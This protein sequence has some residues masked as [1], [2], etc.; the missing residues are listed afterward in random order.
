MPGR[1]RTTKTLAQRINLNYFKNLAPIPRWRR[2]LSVVLTA[3]G[4]LWL[5]WEALAGKQQPYNAGPLAQ[6]HRVFSGNCV[7]CHATEA[8]FGKKVTDEACL[9]CHDGPVHNA[10]QTFTP[11]CI[12]CHVEHK[13]VV[14]LA[15]TRDQACTQC[16]SDLKVK[17]GQT[18]F[19]AN[20]SGFSE[21]HPE[22]AAVR[23]GH[24]KDPGMIKM[25]HQI[26]L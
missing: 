5:G 10:K 15:S 23:T 20:I 26:H 18:Q 2:I 11:A 16:H 4:L 19:A 25:N 21:G 12:D 6:A 13:G 7:S 3:L 9:S 24:A 22:F 14:S 1:T 8:S 17:D